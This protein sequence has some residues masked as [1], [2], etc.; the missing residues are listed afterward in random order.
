M[1]K[2]KEVLRLHYE[3][4]LSTRKIARSLDIGRGTV[5][6]YLDRTQ[7][8]GLSW[9]L[10][11]ELD[12]AT[13]EHRLFPSIPCTVQE[14]RQIPPLE[15]L[16]Q[17]LKKK[18]VTL[19]LLWH[20]YKEKHPNGYQYSQFCRIYRQW[21]E[22]LDPCLR[23]DYRA[24]E[25]LFVDYA[26]QTME[27]TNP[28]TGEVHEA[29]IFVA[30]LGASNYTFAEATLS[31]DLPSW[32]ESHVHAFEF[33]QGVT[34]ILI[35]DNL[36]DAVTRSCRY[37]PDLN[38]TYRELAEHYGA[39]I[40][41]ARVGKARD[42][43]KVESGVLQV[44]RWVLAPLRHR[45]FF[46]LADLNEAIAVQ[47]EILNN[48]PFEKLDATRKRLFETLDKPALKPLPRHRF[49]Y[50]EWIRAKVSIDYHIEVDH[51]YYSVPYQLIHERL[52]VRLTQTTVEIL[53]RGRR[54]ALH[55][56]SSLR[57]KH[58]TLAEHMP[59]SHQK[60]LQWTPSRLIRWA[61]QIGPHTQNL[62]ACILENRP[63]PEQGYRSCLGL[64][65]LGKRY[66]PER[67][68]AACARALAFRAYSYKNVES[69]LKN[70]LDQQPL[71][72]SL[73]QTRLALT[74]HQNLR[75]RKY[76]Q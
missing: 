55:R 69:I 7:R 29:Q 8:A 41:P 32:I 31:Q 75:G 48:R 58:T 43:A 38:A 23:Q 33:F 4:G 11:P 51:H 28:E 39:V 49:T 10:P 6:N 54:V 65:R 46:S 40:I 15:Y 19:Q 26:G 22:K 44:E 73:S 13:L 47:L 76:Y 20:E 68:E 64:L 57:A 53:F 59:K 70:G 45:T 63:H 25:K 42:K 62:V 37:E 34:E 2:I 36:K 66:S 71:D 17:E 74:E 35:P 12:E 24:G 56:R 50:A 18:G 72:A 67:L 14:K 52:D 30:T 5:R 16:H 27:I 61:G 3:K 9:P 21:A 1:R 60:Y